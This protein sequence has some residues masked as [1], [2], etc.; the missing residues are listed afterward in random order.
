M[1]VIAEEATAVA[2]SAKARADEP[3]RNE[4]LPLANFLAL[5]L[6]PPAW[7]VGDLIPRVRPSGDWSAPRRPANP[8]SASSP[9]SSWRAAGGLRHPRLLIDN[10]A[11]VPVVDYDAAIQAGRRGHQPGPGSLDGR[12][13]EAWAS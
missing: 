10:P 1:S 2:D 7:V 8:C 9:A 11:P 12:D 5:K 4:P 13:W 6:Y 3:E